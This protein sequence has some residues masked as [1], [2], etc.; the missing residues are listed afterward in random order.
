M[1]RVQAATCVFACLGVTLLMGC[2]ENVVV[3]PESGVENEEVSVQDAIERDRFVLRPVVIQPGDSCERVHG[4]RAQF[5]NDW[6]AQGNA[7]GNLAGSLWRG[8]I[9]LGPDIELAI[10]ADG[11]AFVHFGDEGYLPRPTDAEVGWGCQ[12]EGYSVNENLLGGESCAIG[13]KSG[14]EH[15]VRGASFDGQRMLMTLQAFEPWDEWCSLQTPHKY[16][17]AACNYSPAPFAELSWGGNG[18]CSYDGEDPTEWTL[19]DCMAMELRSTVCECIGARCMAVTASTA[20]ATM[21]F[22]L[23]LSADGTTLEGGIKYSET[24]PLR[25]QLSRVE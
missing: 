13:P 12:P 2:T 11:S 15:S 4:R 19:V 14:V 21:S 1:N 17:G 8:S 24:G 16:A 25:V 20:Q 22:D 5:R 23:R 7:F 10:A 9:D 18:Q 3:G 6:L